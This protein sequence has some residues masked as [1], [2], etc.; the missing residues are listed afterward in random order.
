[1]DGSTPTCAHDTIRASGVLPS[2]AA[3]LAFISTTAAASPVDFGYSLANPLYLKNGDTLYFGVSVALAS[4]GW[5]IVA[6]GVDL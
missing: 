4:P 3:S 2:L 1:M 6:V 5:A